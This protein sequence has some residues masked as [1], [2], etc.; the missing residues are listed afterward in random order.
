MMYSGKFANSNVLGEIYV[1]VLRLL[2]RNLRS[3]Y[4][5]TPNTVCHLNSLLCRCCCLYNSVCNEVSFD[6][7][8]SIINK[9]TKYSLSAKFHYVL[10]Y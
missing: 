10:S 6:V 8:D 1:N 9:V 4:Y 2:S 3:F 7:F 5:N